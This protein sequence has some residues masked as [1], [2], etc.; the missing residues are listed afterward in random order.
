MI[1][2]ILHQIWFQGYDKM[3]EKIK[4]SH[5]NCK[6]INKNFKIMFWDENKINIFLKQYSE[7]YKFY[8]NLSRIIYKID[9]AR[10]VILYHYGGVFIDMD[11]SCVKNLESLLEKY[12]DKKLLISKLQ[13]AAKLYGL[14]VNNAFYASVPKNNFFIYYLNYIHKLFDEYKDSNDNMN[15]VFQTTG[16]KGLN[17]TIQNYKNDFPIESNKIHKL[18]FYYVE[19]CLLMCLNNEKTYIIHHHESSWLPNWLRF[20]KKNWKI[21]II[22]FILTCILIY[23]LK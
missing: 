11:V 19:P 2:K 8:I 3:P 22:I 12:S 5:L 15:K 21:V 18:D 7:Y 16:P 13:R 10:L 1:P 6:K 17:K 14:E 9:Y 4:K 20:L 23:Y